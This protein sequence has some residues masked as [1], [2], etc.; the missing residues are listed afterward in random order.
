[1]TA[2][3]AKVMDRCVAHLPDGPATQ[4]RVLRFSLIGAIL[5][6]AMPAVLVPAV[7]LPHRWYGWVVAFVVVVGVATRALRSLQRTAHE[8]LAAQSGMVALAAMAVMVLKQAAVQASA[9][10]LTLE[11]KPLTW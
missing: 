11:K 2:A 7:A 9:D 3:N 10:R 5:A 8:T 6:V 4:R 1:M